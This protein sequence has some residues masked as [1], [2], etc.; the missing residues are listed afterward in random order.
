MGDVHRRIRQWQGL[1]R[2]R[3]HTNAA[4]PQAISR[5]HR[6][7]KV[8]FH[9]EGSRGI[10]GELREVEAAPRTRHRGPAHPPTDAGPR[11]QRR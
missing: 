8:R 11:W 7:R 1:R 4:A 9:A 6:E 5:R 10:R 2:S 3:D